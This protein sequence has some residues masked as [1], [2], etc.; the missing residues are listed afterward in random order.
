MY[1]IYA[2]FIICKKFSFHCHIPCPDYQGNPL[3]TQIMTVSVCVCKTCGLP[4]QD[5]VNFIT[6]MRKFNF[7]YQL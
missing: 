3:F 2:G 7:L 5:Y 6:A 4:D 1:E